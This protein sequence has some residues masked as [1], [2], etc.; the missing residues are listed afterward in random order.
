M[1]IT[2]TGANELAAEFRAAAA[3][4]PAALGEALEGY[5][6]T[7][8][9][10]VRAHASGRPGPEI[11]TGE[12]VGSIGVAISGGGP[13]RSVEVGTDEPQ[14]RRLEYGFYGQTDALGR[15]FYQPPY[16]HF[17]PAVDETEGALDAALAAV[18]GLL[19]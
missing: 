18:V 17:G 3:E 8:A 6:D 16:P 13:S 7:L 5:G 1:T 4:L 11:Q 15:T 2:V 19:G 12:Y 9:E 10:A 14:G